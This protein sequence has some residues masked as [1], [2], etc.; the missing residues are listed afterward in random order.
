MGSDPDRSHGRRAEVECPRRGRR[1]QR[2]ETA[3]RDGHPLRSHERGTTMSR[4]MLS[5]SFA[6]LT[7]AP[8]V[9]ALQAE[10]PRDGPTGNLSP[11]AG[12]PGAPGP[13]IRKIEAL[14]DN[15]WLNLGSPAADPKWGKG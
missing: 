14:A 15:T 9:A 8:W 10:P 4:G 1:R 11:L 12:L 5:L 6:L 13:Q 3:A 2:R 7:S